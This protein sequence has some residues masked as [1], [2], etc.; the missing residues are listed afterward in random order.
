MMRTLV[1]AASV[2][3]DDG[4]TDSMSDVTRTYVI[5][6]L[7]RREAY[8][9]SRNSPPI[10]AGCVSYRHKSKSRTLLGESKPR[11]LQWGKHDARAKRCA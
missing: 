7:S 8:K 6:K 11:V 10:A 9:N 2:L 5:I 3:T 1:S 4:A